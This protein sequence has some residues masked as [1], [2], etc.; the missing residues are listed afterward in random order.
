M[1]KKFNFYVTNSDFSGQKIFGYRNLQNYFIKTRPS[2]KC[3][4][5]I[6]WYTY[7]HMNVS[8]RAKNENKLWP[9]KSVEERNFVEL[10]II[11]STW[12]S[13]K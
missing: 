5:K 6:L 7:F 4:K 12:L 9:D 1:L 3:F 13:K 2:I 11:L 8:Y 10:P